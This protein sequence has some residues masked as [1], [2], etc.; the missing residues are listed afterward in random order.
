MVAVIEVAIAVVIIVFGSGT[1]GVGVAWLNDRRL[2]A[3][4]RRMPP[5]D[6]KAILEERLAKGEIDQAEFN[7]KMHTIVFGPPLELDR[8]E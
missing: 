2:A 5:R 3:A 4:A 6:A 1:A 7:Q 8:P